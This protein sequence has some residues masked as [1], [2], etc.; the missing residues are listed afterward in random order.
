MLNRI[1]CVYQN[2]F[3]TNQLIENMHSPSVYDD[4]LHRL[5]ISEPWDED[6]LYY[7][8]QLFS[9]FP[10]NT[11]WI[12]FSSKKIDRSSK[13][14]LNLRQ[15]LLVIIDDFNPFGI[16]ASLYDGLDFE[17]S[18]GLFC[19]FTHN[20]QDLEKVNSSSLWKTG[21]G[22]ALPFTDGEDAV[23]LKQA[24]RLQISVRRNLIREIK[25][26]FKCVVITRH[27]G[28]GVNLLWDDE[29]RY[30]NLVKEW[31]LK[32]ESEY[33]WEDLTPFKDE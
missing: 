8:P 14:L 15:R 28:D 22:L 30:S 13:N 1:R 29:W 19:L 2:L 5:I 3:R 25:T 4:R 11:N 7:Y 32:L 17:G 9:T 33:P 10:L 27:D 6:H 16:I 20:L 18:T 12:V 26:T 31:A 21:P 23:L 24:V